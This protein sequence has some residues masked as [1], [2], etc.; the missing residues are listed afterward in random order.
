MHNNSISIRDELH[1]L[2]EHLS[3]PSPQ[4]RMTAAKQLGEFS[5][6]MVPSDRPPVM[7]ALKNMIFQGTKQS[8]FRF[9]LHA[10]GRVASGEMP[11]HVTHNIPFTKKDAVKI[12]FE[13]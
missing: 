5:E 12:V 8:D 3:D 10:L 13:A 9:G 7:C 2:L 4:I 6:L 11:T 1:S